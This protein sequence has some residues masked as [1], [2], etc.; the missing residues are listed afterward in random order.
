LNER[1]K[2]IE[3]K[4]IEFRISGVSIKDLRDRVEKRKKNGGEAREKTDVR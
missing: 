1:W 2:E 4:T 3:A